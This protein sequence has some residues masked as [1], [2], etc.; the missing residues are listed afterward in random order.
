MVDVRYFLLSMLANIS[1][2]IKSHL[3]CPHSYADDTRLY[4]SFCP[5]EGTSEAEALD[6]ME[7]C[8]ADVCSWMINDKLMLNDDTTEF[9]VIG[10]SKQLS[11]VSVSSIRVGDGGKKSGFLVRLAHG[12]GNTYNKDLP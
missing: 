5:L 6:V 11:K 4:L 3:P 8:I 9:L 2:K 10:T 12:Y 7:N 1:V